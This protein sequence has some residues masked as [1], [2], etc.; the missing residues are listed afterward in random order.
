MKRK[1]EELD[2]SLLTTKRRY[3]T[4]PDHLRDP[5]HSKLE[6]DPLQLIDGSKYH[7]NIAGRVS[8]AYPVVDDNTTFKIETLHHGRV[9][10]FEVVISESYYE[11]IQF[12]DDDFVV[13]SLT[14][15]E[16]V[17]VKPLAVPHALPFFLYYPQ[18]IIMK[19]LARAQC[20]ENDGEII[21]TF[22]RLS[23]SHIFFQMPNHPLYR[24][25][26]IRKFCCTI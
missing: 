8:A 5:L 20:P 24:T 11:L 7:G 26:C 22:S 21:D 13:L 12:Q 17:G 3:S 9:G 1:A 14:G 18:G 15:A 16:V 10:R 23:F 6:Q 4:S 25:S 2:I 19:F